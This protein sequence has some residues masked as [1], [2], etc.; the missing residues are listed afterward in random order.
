MFLHSSEKFLALFHLLSVWNP[1][2]DAT[3]F[4]LY[5]ETNSAA[6]T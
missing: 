4:T 5:A 6:N 2:R 3:V 1:I